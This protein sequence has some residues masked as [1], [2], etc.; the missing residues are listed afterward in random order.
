MGGI[1]SGIYREN[2]KAVVENHRKLDIFEL[3][4]EG[5]LSIGKISGF[6]WKRKDRG[7]SSPQVQL[8]MRDRDVLV[9]SYWDYSYPV[10]KLVSYNIT[11]TYTKNPCTHRL[12]YFFFCPMCSRR[13]QKLFA[14]GNK[15]LFACSGSKCRNL[16]YISR[17]KSGDLLSQLHLKQKRIEKKLR[18][19]GIT[20]N[21]IETM[22]KPKFLHNRTFNKLVNC[23]KFIIKQKE[24]YLK[25]CSAKLGI[26]KKNS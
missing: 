10:P 12:R 14:T 11:L 7:M 20:T 2:K 26:I 4:R 5:V 19:V 6:S 22:K 8:Y 9:A 24:E 25:L 23:Y 16:S 3:A 15:L 21:N 17:Q 18:A 13:V 1:G